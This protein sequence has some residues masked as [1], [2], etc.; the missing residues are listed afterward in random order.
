MTWGSVPSDLD[1]TFSA[2]R[3]A[4]TQ[5]M[6]S[7]AELGV[8]HSYNQTPKQMVEEFTRQ[9]PEGDVDKILA[10]LVPGA[11]AVKQAKANLEAAKAISPRL[12]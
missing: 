3:E 10:Q 2:V 1:Q 12:N 5:L 6:Q 4:Q 11:P 9:N 8:I 7:T